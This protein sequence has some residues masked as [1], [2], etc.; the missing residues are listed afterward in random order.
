MFY[1]SYQVASNKHA[2]IRYKV[3]DDCFSNFRRKYYF[4][5]LMEK[6]Q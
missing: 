5:D 6:M 3:L 1:V 2:Q 4:D